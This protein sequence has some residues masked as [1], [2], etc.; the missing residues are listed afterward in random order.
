M[1]EF[2]KSDF[3][4]LDIIIDALDEDTKKNLMR[5]G[6]LYFKRYICS[7]ASMLGGSK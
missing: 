3:S 2:D 4:K 5:L 6:F 1:S 7:L